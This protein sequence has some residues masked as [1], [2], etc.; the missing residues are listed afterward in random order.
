MKYSDFEKATTR[1]NFVCSEC[2][3][4]VDS[5]R[6]FAACAGKRDSR[7]GAVKAQY[8]DIMIRYGDFPNK[9][10]NCRLYDGKPKRKWYQFWRLV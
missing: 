3:H 1:G 8:L 6:S 9:D 10:G 7:T 5:G 2:R 4:C